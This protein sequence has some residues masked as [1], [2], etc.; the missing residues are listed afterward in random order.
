MRI[1]EVSQYYYPYRGGQEAYVRNLSR[2]LAARGHKVTVITTSQGGNPD[3]DDQGIEVLRHP[4]RATL[5]NNPLSLAALRERSVIEAADVVHLHNDHS[6]L[7]LS[8]A[9]LLGRH[10][11][12]IVL[13]LHGQLKFGS[14]LLDLIEKAYTWSLGNFL[15][16]QSDRV[17]ANSEEDGLAALRRGVPPSRLVQVWNAVDDA[18]LSRHVGLL[19]RGQVLKRLGLEEEDKLV[20]YVGRLIER[21]GIRALVAAFRTVLSRVPG[22]Q[23]LLIGDGPLRGYCERMATTGGLGE[24]LKIVTQ[25]PDSLLYAT[26]QAADVFVLPS[27]SETC[28]TVVLEA[29][30][31]GCQVVTTDIPGIRDHFE[32]LASLVPP[33]N[34]G[35]L[36]AAISRHLLRGRGESAGLTPAQELIRNK[37]NWNRV[38]DMYLSAF[39]T[40]T[41]GKTTWGG[42]GDAG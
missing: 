10:H 24:H 11:S 6:F 29:L 7:S 28:P 17:F 27:I 20:M 14:G 5:L 21:K 3:S 9:F 19:T 33:S 40:L 30:F 35:A 34:P 32:G 25:M 26:Y 16:R 1:V 42:E 36:A 8:V 18:A 37:Y 4:T 41:R 13:T 15:V 38:S 23:L 2:A 22:A 12:P 31:F 39:E